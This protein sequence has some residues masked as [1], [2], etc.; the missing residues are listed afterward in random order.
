VLPVS[1]CDGRFADVVLA[2]VQWSPVGAFHGREL[3]LSGRDRKSLS[4]AIRTR[5]G[6]FRIAGAEWL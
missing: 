1:T 2:I 6:A 4:F 3:F 5:C